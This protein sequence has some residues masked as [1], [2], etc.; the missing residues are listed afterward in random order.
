MK[1]AL[2]YDKLAEKKVLCRLCH[3]HCHIASGKR[4]LCA[5][6]AKTRMASC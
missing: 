1:E 2:F 3:H 5:G 4:G 6:C